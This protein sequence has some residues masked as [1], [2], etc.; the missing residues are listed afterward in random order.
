MLVTNLFRGRK[1]VDDGVSPALGR[2]IE[3]GS[4]RRAAL[5]L[6]HPLDT[7]SYKYFLS[8]KANAK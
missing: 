5:F 2:G 6:Y 1:Q 3:D 8:R 7:Y 4:I